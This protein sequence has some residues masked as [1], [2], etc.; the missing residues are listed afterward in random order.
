MLIR[1]IS[2]I[3]LLTH[4]AF[5][6]E[7]KPLPN[8]KIDWNF[9][10]IMGYFNRES[11]Q[12]GYKV[13]KEVCAACH[14]MKRVSFRNLVDIGFSEDEVKQIAAS[15]QVTDGPNDLGEMFERNGT[16]SDYFVPPFNNK[17]AA[18]SA[19]N[20]VVPPDLSL[21]IKAR[22]DGA[23]YVYS[24]LTGYKNGEQSEDGLY[25]NPYFPAG[26]LAMAAP[27]SDGLVQYDNDKQ[28]TVENM[29]YDVVNF[30]QWASEPE[31]ESRHKLGLKVIA[32][33]I[34]LTVL[35]ILTNNKLWRN[36]YQK[37]H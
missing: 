19:N 6:E 29:A 5:A 27:L 32:Y 37:K 8:K 31:L 4:T 11:I 1:I 14:S 7:F 2:F 16:P 23:N 15:Y 34:V 17:E 22:H 10:G 26:K 28:S 12:R 35:F 24:L 3:L 36:L 20:G 30:L 18:A 33:F 25:S 21:I 9:E 13:Y